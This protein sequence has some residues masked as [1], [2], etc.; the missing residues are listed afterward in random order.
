MIREVGVPTDGRAIAI[1]EYGA[2]TA[3][4]AVVATAAGLSDHILPS[5]RTG[6]DPGRPARPWLRNHADGPR[7]ATVEAT[8]LG[9]RRTRAILE[10]RPASNR[11]RGSAGSRVALPE[12]LRRSG[13]FALE[14]RDDAA[15][16]ERIDDLEA[17]CRES[18]GR[19]IDAVARRWWRSHPGDPQAARGLAIVADG[20]DRLVE[21]LG[22][23]KRLIADPRA[24]PDRPWRAGT[25]HHPRPG[26]PR[27]VAFVYPG[28]G[29]HHEGMGREL[30]LLWPDVLR[31]Q[32]GETRSL[33]DQL[34]PEVWWD[35]PLP[36]SFAD[37]RV[38]ILGQVA[39]GSLVTDIL[40][41]FGI[42]PDAAIGYSMGES[43]AL[44]AL[45]VWRARDELADRL[46]TSPLFATELVGPCDAAR[47]AWG[48]PP[49][50]AVDWAAG[51]VPRSADDVREAIESA[52]AGRVFVLI[53]NTGAETLVGGERTA[54]HEVVR[55]LRCP[56]IVMTPVGTVHCP[57]GRLV[58]SEYRALH[59]IETFAPSGTA[60]YSG[61][62]GRRYPVRPRFGGGCDRRTRVA[63]HRFPED[64]RECL[65]RRHWLVHRGRP[66]QLVLAD[67]RGDSR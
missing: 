66:G 62:T 60:F 12:S 10:E 59:D 39:L 33:R 32:D 45:R 1:A 64:H 5:A 51:V 48:I 29:N 63:K 23:A 7:Q 50:Q 3:L 4:A 49:G 20:I 44:V 42:T 2:V 21:L 55:A 16:L 43:A 54:V 34:A 17:L 46:R 57:I 61:V 56:S 67:G 13:L 14:G 47:R 40:R 9:G 24:V 18:G 31:R 30:G 65:C 38:P 37:I 35:S 28:L 58:E 22:P 26:T 11:P 8:S 19:S 27:G 6:A 25:I 41:G 15:I 53:R 36:L 52:G